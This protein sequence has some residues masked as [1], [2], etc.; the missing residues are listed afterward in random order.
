MG[1]GGIRR[2]AADAFRHQP[3]LINPSVDGTGYYAVVK[4]A[5]TPGVTAERSGQL[6]TA[7]TAL[8]SKS[9]ARWVSTLATGWSGITSGLAMTVTW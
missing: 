7:A 1:Q 4:H 2:R 6:R 9:R 8:T 3:R 5:G